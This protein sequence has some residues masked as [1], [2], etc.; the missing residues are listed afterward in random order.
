MREDIFKNYLLGSFNF[1]ASVK[2]FGLI[3]MVIILLNKLNPLYLKPKK[4]DIVEQKK[5]AELVF[6]LLKKLQ[7]HMGLNFIK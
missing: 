5:I 3:M 6:H 7:M 1:F 4:K 2:Y